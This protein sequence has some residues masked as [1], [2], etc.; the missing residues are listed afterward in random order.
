MLPLILIIFL[1][2][3]LSFL[4]RQLYNK[5][6]KKKKSLRFFSCLIKL[7]RSSRTMMKQVVRKWF[8]RKWYLHFT[9]AYICYSF[10]CRN[11]SSIL[12]LPKVAVVLVMKERM[13]KLL[14]GFWEFLML[15][16]FYHKINPILYFAWYLFYLYKFLY[17]QLNST[18]HL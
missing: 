10:L 3:L 13:L 14:T 18:I 12:Y 15:N 4:F 9:I 11:F 7:A 1:W 6:F 5:W 2:I 16:Q 17:F 8:L